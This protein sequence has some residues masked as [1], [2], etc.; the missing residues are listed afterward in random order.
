[1]STINATMMIMVLSFTGYYSLLHLLNN[2]LY[3]HIIAILR[4][5]PPFAGFLSK[6]NNSSGISIISFRVG[7]GVG[8]NYFL[9]R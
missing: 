2:Y 9:K 6:Y 5:L 4:V 3:S 7:V 1:M 8:S